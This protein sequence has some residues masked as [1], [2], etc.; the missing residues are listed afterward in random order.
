MDS[1]SAQE[2]AIRELPA[3]AIFS[4]K[5]R[6]SLLSRLFFL[7]AVILSCSP[8][9]VEAQIGRRKYPKDVYYTA[10]ASFNAGEYRDAERLFS[11][12]ARG[13]YAVGNNRWIDSVC[14]YAMIGECYYRMGNLP[15][16]MSQYDSALKV[17][18]ANR[19]WMSRVQYPDT[20]QPSSSA[21]SRARVT[22]MKSTRMNSVGR[23]S[24]ELSVVTGN[25]RSTENVLKQGGAVSP[26]ELRQLNVTEVVRCASLAIRRKRELMGPTGRFDPLTNQLVTSL[27]EFGTGANH[28]AR[29]WEEIQLALANGLA[30][31]TATAVQGLGRSITISRVIDHPLTP[32]AL[33]ELGKLY[34]E[35][36]NYD[37]AINFLEEATCSGAVFEQYDVIEEAFTF[38]THA[39]L[40]KKQSSAVKPLVQAL[41]WAGTK[42]SKQLQA[43]LALL[44]AECFLSVGAT[45]DAFAAL[46]QARRPMLR[47]DLAKSDLAPVQKYQSAHAA[48]QKG[49]SSQGNSF[50]RAAVADLGVS[51]RWLFQK[52]Q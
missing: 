28:W 51:G 35:Q 5:K 49:D 39:Q 8:N 11:T 31:D 37:E 13:G 18:I 33:L 2:L 9:F 21:V 26:T 27:S 6:L 14:Y 30:G 17:L 23:F 16:A 7:A 42:G 40:I 19:G 20:I 15:Q 22:W 52:F 36:G 45:K 41:G 12:A 1:V 10:K 24:T 43:R 29:P 46:S 48:F 4:N 38:A 32:V 34:F 25:F 47:N 50:L 3:S 44:K